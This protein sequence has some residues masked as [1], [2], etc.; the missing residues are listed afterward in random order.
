MAECKATKHDDCAN[1]IP[2]DVSK[3]MC[4]WTNELI[5]TDSDCCPKFSPLQKCKNCK[6]Y[7]DATEDGLGN[8]VGLEDKS[9][10][11]YGEM[12]AVNCEGWAQK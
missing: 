2:V 7:T 12:P 5:A 1:F 11:A 10:W 3:G 6:N 9:F 4:A 8:C